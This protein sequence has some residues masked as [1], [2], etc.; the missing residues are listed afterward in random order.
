MT[1]STTG[2][3]LANSLRR[4]KTSK[5]EENAQTSQATSTAVE[6]APAAEKPVAKKPAARK[7]APPKTAAVKPVAKKVEEE[8]VVYLQSS[9]RRWPD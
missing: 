7:P 1:T 5:N 3:K 2:S 6:K 9:N 8:K 4:A